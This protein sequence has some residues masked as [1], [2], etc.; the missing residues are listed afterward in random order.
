[1]ED[2]APKLYEKI[3]ADFEKEINNNKF[4]QKFLKKIEEEK[5]TSEQ[6]SIYA[7][8]IGECASK[9]L[10][11]NITIDNLPDGKLYWNIAERTIKPLIQRCH[12]MINDAAV[13][14]LKTE[15]VKNGFHINPVR[16]EFNE[17]RVKS[18]LDKISDISIE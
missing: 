12:E 4:I 11:K 16:A 6:A 7:R 1:M 5:A 10:Q 17:E 15:N 3:L 9:A 18:F 13:K 2:I 14:V 8:K